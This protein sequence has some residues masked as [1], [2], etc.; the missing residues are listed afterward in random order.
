MPIWEE[1]CRLGHPAYSPVTS[2]ARHSRYNTPDVKLWHRPGAFVLRQPRM[3]GRSTVRDRWPGIVLPRFKRLS[4]SKGGGFIM[5]L[6]Y[7]V[8]RETCRSDR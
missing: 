3:M 7:R 5:L 2:V 8:S 1:G 4:T 6:F